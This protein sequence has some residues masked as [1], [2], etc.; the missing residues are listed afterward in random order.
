M[1][2]TF[3]A[4]GVAATGMKSW[5]GCVVGTDELLSVQAVQMKEMKSKHL[6]VRT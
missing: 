1:E 4:T 2:A 3:R 5:R 6:I